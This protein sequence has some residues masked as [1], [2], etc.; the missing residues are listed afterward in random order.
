MMRNYDM[1]NVLVV[2]FAI[3]GLACGSTNDVGESDSGNEGSPETSSA[4]TNAGSADASTAASSSSADDPSTSGT[5]TSNEPLDTTTEGL[6]IPE[7]CRAATSEDACNAASDFCHWS[8]A[9]R[10]I[11]LATCEL[12]PAPDLQ[13][14]SRYLE[15]MNCGESYPPA[16]SP[17][18]VAPRHREVDGQLQLLDALCA[19]GPE[20]VPS[21]QPDWEI[22]GSDEFSPQPDVCYCMC[23][24]PLPPP[25]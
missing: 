16:C 10:V 18:G 22:C 14:W 17:Y 21:D 6:T 12:E 19:F 2:V 3:G 24:G 4:S 7:L 13:C 1:R 25:E 9:Y 11:D 23:G 5:S 15:G 20:P 8:A